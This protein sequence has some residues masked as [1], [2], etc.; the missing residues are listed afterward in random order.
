MRSASASSASVPYSPLSSICCQRQARGERHDQRTIRLRLRARHDRAA[1][2]RHHAPTA[3]A[4]LEPH[5][6]ALL[7]ACSRRNA[8]VT[9]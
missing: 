5:R 1:V 8:Q 2:G 3:A 6:D 4:V 9:M 7:N